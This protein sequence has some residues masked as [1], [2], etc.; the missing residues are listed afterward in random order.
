MPPSGEA[1]GAPHARALLGPQEITPSATM[2]QSTA[3]H[4]PL[5]N[6]GRQANPDIQDIITGIVKLL[7]GNV[8]VQANTQ[9]AVG[10]PLRPFS[11]RINNRGPP[12][13]T[14]V[15]ALPPDFDVPALPP[16][17]LGMLYLY[18]SLASHLF[19]FDLKL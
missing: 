3:S 2:S 11:T 17:P 12:R 6:Q 7:N 14:D 4:S 18:Q 19:N 1:W 9:P 15:P 8:N 13:I 16:P 10:R 5:P